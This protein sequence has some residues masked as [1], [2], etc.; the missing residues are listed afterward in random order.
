MQAMRQSLIQR[1]AKRLSFWG[2]AL[3]QSTMPLLQYNPGTQTMSFSNNEELFFNE[4][5]H[6]I[7]R[8]RE[9]SFRSKI[10]SKPL[11]FVPTQPCSSTRLLFILLPGSLP[12]L[13][14][15]VSH[16]VLEGRCQPGGQAL[17]AAS[18]SYRYPYI[19]TLFSSLLYAQEPFWV[20]Y[21]RFS[22][23]QT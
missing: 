10:A 12:R 1:I 23:I 18:Q 6:Q 17:W 16:S 7:M 5:L 21:A 15:N 3:Y 13:L 22:A 4:K 9:S 14:I 20:L 11:W 19:F 8:E 2:S